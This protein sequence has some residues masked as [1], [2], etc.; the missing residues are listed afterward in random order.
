LPIRGWGSCSSDR[1]KG[2]AHTKEGWRSPFRALVPRS[3]RCLIEDAAGRF[4][5]CRKK[6]RGGWKEEA[7]PE[8]QTASPAVPEGHTPFPHPPAGGS[9]APH[10]WAASSKCPAFVNRNAP[11]I[12][13]PP[14]LPEAALRRQG[15]RTSGQSEVDAFSRSTV[16]RT[17]P[18]DQRK[19]WPCRK[20]D[21]GSDAGFPVLGPKACIR[22]C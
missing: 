12:S 21:T 8:G 14:L 5:G 7:E 13:H 18:A 9:D 11:A 15:Q 10:V 3:T 16:R 6:D 17:A 1:P 4:A 20:N 19:C 22:D 2:R